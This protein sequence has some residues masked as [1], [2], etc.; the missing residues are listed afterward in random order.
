[1]NADTDYQT[2]DYQTLEDKTGLS[3]ARVLVT[4]GTRGIGAATVRRLAAA[5]ARVVAAAR[6]VPERA[7]PDWPVPEQTAAEW[8]DDGSCRFVAADVATADGVAALA[9]Q[10]L[11]LLGG[12]D[13]LVSNA[14]SQTHRPEGILGFSDEDWQHDLDINLLSAVR[15]DRALLPAMIAQ[16][17]R[18]PRRCPTR[19][20]RRP[21]PPT[22]RGSPGRPA[23]TA[24]ASIRSCPASSAPRRSTPGW[25]RS[26]I[27]RAPHQRRCSRPRSPHWA[28]RLGGRGPPTTSPS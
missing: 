21:S 3:G 23:R 7:V 4:G 5:G 24:S 13:I 16:G 15:L 28:S 12:I 2:A 26:P 6:T 14:G 8:P 27:S 20:P 22:A 10:A 25:P 18:G 19:R 11:D 1:M 17:R 9:A